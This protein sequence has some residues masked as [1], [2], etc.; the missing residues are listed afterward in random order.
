MSYPNAV[1][2]WKLSIVD[3]QFERHYHASNPHLIIK[4]QRRKPLLMSEII[5]GKGF[6]DA[7]KYIFMTDSLIC[8]HV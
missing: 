4:K 3:Y 6:H 1:H 5:Y 2:I 8:L 7:K